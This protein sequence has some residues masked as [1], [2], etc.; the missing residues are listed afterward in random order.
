MLATSDHRASLHKIIQPTLVIQGDHDALTREAAAARM[1]AAIP[2]A[3][4]LKIEHAAHAPFLSHREAFL[5]AL[6][7]FLN[8]EYAQAAQSPRT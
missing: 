2:N 1:A 7:Y 4:Y 6:N 3:T 5:N 8:T